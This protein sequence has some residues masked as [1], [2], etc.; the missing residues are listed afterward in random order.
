MDY[1]FACVTRLEGCYTQLC[2]TLN[3]HSS[4]LPQVDPGD[5]EA[6]K[7]MRTSQ[8]A[9]PSVLLSISSAVTPSMP[10]AM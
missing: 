3:R 6:I 10:F 7:K 9:L 2:K 1:R 8:S 4:F 5:D